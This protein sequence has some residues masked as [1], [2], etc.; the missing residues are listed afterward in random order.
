MFVGT[1][2]WAVDDYLSTLY[3]DIGAIQLKT[4]RLERNVTRDD[5]VSADSPVP[6]AVEYAVYEIES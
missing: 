6:I 5:V 3:I 1:S 4:K 2:P